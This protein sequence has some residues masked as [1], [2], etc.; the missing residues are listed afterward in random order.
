LSA[1]VADRLLRDFLAPLVLG[2]VMTPG[3]PIGA[4]VALSLGAQAETLDKELVSHLQLGRVRCARLLAPV[5]RLPPPG[6]DDLA[7]AAALHDVVQATHPGFDRVM[8]RSAPAKLL[9]Y[10]AQILD[11]VPA[12]RSVGVALARHTL[13]ARALE[14]TRTDTVVS[15]WAGKQTFL[16]ETPSSSAM[17][18]PRLRRVNKTE[19]RHTLVELPATGASVDPAR[20]TKVLSAFLART[21]LTDVATATRVSPGFAWTSE[22]L[23]LVATARGRAIALRALGLSPTLRVDEALGSATRKLFEAQAWSAASIALE[24]LKER[25]IADAMAPSPAQEKTKADADAAFARAAGALAA[26]RQLETDP[27][28]PSA[29]RARVAATLDPLTRSELARKIEAALSRLSA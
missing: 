27:S 4:K 20:F 25:A 1:E 16:G 14:I 6:A 5:D 24:L 7:M 2:G 10:A 18:W 15:V 22:T 11:R 23:S 3:R 19:A 21:P 9:E 29:E 13:F 17:M 28:I 26:R 12:P 8:R